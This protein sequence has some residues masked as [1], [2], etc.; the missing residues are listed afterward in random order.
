MVDSGDKGS[1][2]TQL[3]GLL[4]AAWLVVTIG[5]CNHS[6]DWSTVCSMVGGA[7]DGSVTTEVTGLLCAAWI[8]MMMV[9]L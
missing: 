9:V 2:T 5:F 1:V 4:C 7:D 8:T 6:V 3:T